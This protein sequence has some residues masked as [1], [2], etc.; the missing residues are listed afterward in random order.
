MDLIDNIW[1]FPKQLVRDHYIFGGFFRWGTPG[2]VIHV[3]DG[4]GVPIFTKPPYILYSN[5][6]LKM[7]IELDAMGDIGNTIYRGVFRKFCT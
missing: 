3:L 4:F 5:Y 2:V 6:T 1:R 7:E